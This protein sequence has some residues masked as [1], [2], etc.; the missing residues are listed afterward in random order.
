[1]FLG[2]KVGERHRLSRFVVPLRIDATRFDDTF[3]ELIDIQSID[4]RSDWLSGLQSVLNLLQ[5]DGVPRSSSFRADQFGEMV[6]SHRRRPINLARTP[7]ALVSNI[8]P[9]VT[10]PPNVNFFNVS[11]I[12]TNK[13]KE[14]ANGLSVPAFDH[15]ALLGTWASG[16]RLQK[17]LDEL[18]RGETKVSLRSSVPLSDYLHAKHGDLPEWR[19][20]DARHKTFAMFHFAWW[21][22]AEFVGDTLVCSRTIATSRSSGPATCLITK[23]NL[24]I[25]LA[26]S[27]AASSLG[28]ARSAACIGTSVCKREVSLRKINLRT[29]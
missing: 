2:L 9:I 11:G 6:A 5:R 15:Y 13:L 4:F 20:S 12:Q 14:V 1:M 24:P 27:F 18:N 22:H 7:E 28:L 23:S 8:L 16:E 19:R 26:A 17:A 29:R 21:K 25:S 3:I 10:P